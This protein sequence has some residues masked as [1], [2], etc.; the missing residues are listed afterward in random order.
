MALN[1]HIAVTADSLRTNAA[2]FMPIIY[3]HDCEVGEQSTDFFRPFEKTSE[4]ALIWCKKEPGAGKGSEVVFK[5]TAGF[6]YE[7][8]I[9]DEK[10][11]DAAYEPLKNGTYKLKVDF[12]RHGASYT[13]RSE[14]QS[15]LLNEFKDKFPLEQGKWNGRLKTDNL[16]FTF[17]ELTQSSN[18]QFAGSASSIDTLKKTDTMS[19]NVITEFAQKLKT[20]N[21]KPA[22]VGYYDDGQPIKK[23]CVVATTETLN[24]LERD[25][26]YL[27]NMRD[28]SERSKNENYIFKGG[29]SNVR[30]NIVKEYTPIDHDGQG[31]IGSVL[32]PK[33]ELGVAL[34]D[35]D[36]ADEIKGGGY[37]DASTNTRAKFFRYFPNYAYRLSPDETLATD[38]GTYYYVAIVNPGHAATDPGKFGFYKYTSNDGTTLTIDSALKSGQDVGGLTWN[39]DKNTRTHPEGAAI[40]LV[41]KDCV[42]YGWS[43]MMG[44]GAALRGYGSFKH[45]RMVD[46][47]EGGFQRQV[48]LAS[49]FGQKA[50]ED[51]R[52][53]KPG[54]ISVCH[55][56]NIPGLDL[57][58]EMA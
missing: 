11:T 8:V 24:S 40:Y 41:N 42:P 2:D 28:A 29:Y 3:Q 45:K 30:G 43:I 49:I 4:E 17:R 47:Q 53:R 1:N 14:E 21:G 56:L 32:S 18:Q 10:F 31:A 52:N 39:A 37:A 46:E 5:T 27:R 25:P 19:N 51:A 44:A 38:G 58:P 54:F 20:M 23:Y 13:L 34:T 15:A 9:G 16:F 35:A 50:R 36:D 57:D 33:A 7:P 22:Q 55:A 12:F 48:Y 26:D 6:Y